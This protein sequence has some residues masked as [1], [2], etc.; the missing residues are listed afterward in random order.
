MPRTQSTASGSSTHEV[1]IAR[2]LFIGSLTEGRTP[3]LMWVVEKVQPS[4]CSAAGLSLPPDTGEP[5]H[6]TC[7]EIALAQSPGQFPE[8]LLLRDLSPAGPSPG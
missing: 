2:T 5:T 1:A 4:H 7:A 6:I 8:I 3:S